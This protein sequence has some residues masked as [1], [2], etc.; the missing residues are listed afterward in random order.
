MRIMKFTRQARSGAATA[1][2]AGAALLA[3]CDVTNPGPI[4]DEFLTEEEAQPGLINGAIRSIASAYDARVLDLSLMAREVFPGGQIGSWGTGVAMHAGHVQRENGGSFVAFHEA[5]F[6]TETAIDRFT[7]VAASDERMYEAWLWNGYAYRILA[8]Q[9]C[10]TV[11]PTRD[12]ESADPPEFIP[13]TSDPYME[14]AVESFS[15]ALDYASGDD[16]LDAALAG[17][18][19]AHLWLGN[20]DEAYADAAEVTDE[21]FVF[22]LE[23][24]DTET[25]LYNYMAEGNSGTFR[26]YTTEF[27]WFN[28]HHQDTGDPRVPTALDPDNPVA[29]GSLTGY[30]G[31]SVPYRRQTKYTARTDHFNL[32]SYWEMRLI[33]AEAVLRGASSGTVAEAVGLIN[34]VR[35]RPEVDIDP[36][37]APTAEEAW[38]VLMRERRIELWLEGRSAPDERR[39]KADPPLGLTSGEIEAMLPIPDWEGDDPSGSFTSH[40]AS[41]PRGLDGDSSLLCFD[42]PAAER[43]R[44]PNVPNVQQGS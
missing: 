32:A 37:V 25:V 44:N 13:N 33:M 19:A 3:G 12:S 24:D 35:T 5:R 11:L 23:Q 8:E 31:G 15:N 43:D 29:V 2:V 22:I 18:A 9:F 16:Q 27:T 34:E 14:R 28:Q 26:S 17:R 40:F 1:V 39:W 10:E 36:V 20:W 30:P 38:R 42:I 7:K 6:I 41:N 21:D 4:Q